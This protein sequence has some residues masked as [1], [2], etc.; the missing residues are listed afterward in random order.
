MLSDAVVFVIVF[1]GL[2]VAR[3]IVATLL[4]ILILPPGDRCPICD[5]HTLRIQHR[6]WNT[7]FPGFRTSWCPEC[8]WEG[9]QRDAAP[10]RVRTRHRV[11]PSPPARSFVNPHDP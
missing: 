11:A 8:R 4:F 7:L 6:A 5:A 1:V 3:I 2:F 9:L 10:R